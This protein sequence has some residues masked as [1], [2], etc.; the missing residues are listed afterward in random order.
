MGSYKACGHTA[1][2]YTN[3]AWNANYVWPT[4]CP[5][6]PTGSRTYKVHKGSDCACTFQGKTLS[7]DIYNNYPEKDPAGC[8]GDSCTKSPGMYASLDSI[9]YYGSTCGAWDQM[10]ATPWHSYCPAS[11]DWCNPDYNWCQQPWC[12]V[13]AKCATGVTSSVFKGSPVAFYSYNTCLNSPDCYTNVAWNDDFGTNAPA[14]CPF[15][16]S[17]NN[18]YTA[19][20]CPNGF[21]SPA[22]ATPALTKVVVPTDDELA[23]DILRPIKDKYGA[24]LSWADLIVIA[25]SATLEELSARVVKVDVCP[26]RVDDEDGSSSKYLDPNIYLDAEKATAEDVKES[27]R[28][29]GLSHREMT[30]L[31][32]GGHTLGKKHFWKSGFNGKWTHTPTVLSN[33]FFHMLLEHEWVETVVPETGKRQFTDRAGEGLMMLSTD[34]VFMT[35]PDFVNYSRMYKDD[36]R[37]FLKDFEAAW[38]KLI[39]ADR[40]GNAC[41]GVVKTSV[42][43]PAPTINGGVLEPQEEDVNGS[44]TLRVH[45]MVLWLCLCVAFLLSKLM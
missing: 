1:D 8:E 6:D 3:I 40:F 13:D 43:T 42:P 35:D 41:K 10:P 39:N 33:S 38:E 7:A 27:M 32:G 20:L 28:I 25:G 5:Y 37:L 15:D 45:W 31:N 26:G 18:W 22:S 30:V 12:Y 4:G 24:G 36:N 9:K 19:K 16:A 29:M 34:L 44:G 23:I 17:D 11:S 21:T 2:C 14:E